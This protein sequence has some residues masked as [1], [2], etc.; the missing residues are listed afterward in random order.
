MSG[1]LGKDTA[2]WQRL[3]VGIVTVCTISVSLFTAAM[4]LLLQ[5]AEA[6]SRGS[7]TASGVQHP[8]TRVFVNDVTMTARS[9]VECKLMLEDL[10]KL[11]SWAL[12]EI[13][14]EKSRSLIL[15][16]GRVWNSNKAR[17]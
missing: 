17:F 13:K 16:K 14:P 3:E 6:I 4:H 11:V 9:I 1:S 15:E 10:E 12:M 5:S 8:P 7:Y 2:D